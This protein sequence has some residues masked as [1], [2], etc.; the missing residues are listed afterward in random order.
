MAPY[1]PVLFSTYS[2]INWLRGLPIQTYAQV[3]STV[4]NRCKTANFNLITNSFSNI[5]WSTGHQQAEDVAVLLG[6]QLPA[7][8]LPT[9]VK[10]ADGSASTTAF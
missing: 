5:Y 4:T 7:S 1:V 10:H 8:T 3:A 6:Q 9:L 2:G